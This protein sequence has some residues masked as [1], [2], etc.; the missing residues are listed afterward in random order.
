MKLFWWVFLI[1]L[2]VG[3][4]FASLWFIKIIP[5][6]SGLAAEEVQVHNLEAQLKLIRTELQEKDKLLQ[7]AEQERADTAQ[8]LT[9]KEFEIQKLQEKISD[10]E[11][12][13]NEIQTP[14][15]G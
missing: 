6:Q 1:V 11:K 9:L 3:S 8:A 7:K 5:L 13:L 10:L 4:T 15:K 2:L 12:Q 14:G